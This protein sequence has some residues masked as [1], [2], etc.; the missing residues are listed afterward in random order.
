M[1]SMLIIGATEDDARAFVGIRPGSQPGDPVA[2]DRPSRA[3]PD[4]LWP[5][6]EVWSGVFMG[7]AVAG[8][9]CWPVLGDHP[10]IDAL[11]ITAAARAIY[12]VDETTLRAWSA[13]VLGPGGWL[14]IQPDPVSHA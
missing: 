10:P 4:E 7:A 3:V 13:D 9:L 1:R 8:V 5:Q 14:Y 11:V 12:E 6:G 2:E